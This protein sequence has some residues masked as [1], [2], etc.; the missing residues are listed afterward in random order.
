MSTPMRSTIAERAADP[1][2]AQIAH[3]GV[4]IESLEFAASR[5]HQA[6]IRS[7]WADKAKYLQELFGQRLAA[8]ITGVDDARTVGRWIRGQ[9]PQHAQ[10]E[11]LRDA[12]QTAMLIELAESRETAKAWFL[13]MNPGLN[14]EPPAQVIAE[15]AQNGG[16]RVMKAARSFLAS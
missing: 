2:S 11:R 12:Y 16:K 4:L 10:R 13:G 5:A 1:E 9:E 6:V 3:T 15:D 8:A 7:T 14:D